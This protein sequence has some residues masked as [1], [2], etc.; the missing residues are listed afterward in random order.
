MWS[1][2]KPH[3]LLIS[4]L[5]YAGLR[6]GEA[7][8]LRRADLAVSGGLVLVDEDQVKASGTLVFDTP[9]SHQ[10]RVGTA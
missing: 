2:T 6:V 8:A 4:L 5:A 10:K 3:D 9:K 7:F 1:A